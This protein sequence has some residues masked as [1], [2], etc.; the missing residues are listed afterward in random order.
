M[1]HLKT[2]WQ[3]I[4]FYFGICPKCGEKTIRWSLHKV[5]CSKCGG[6]WAV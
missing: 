2:L 6:D 5:V 4:K 3:K 1:N